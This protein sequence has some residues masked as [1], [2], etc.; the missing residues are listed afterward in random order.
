[1]KCLE[2]EEETVVL[3]EKIVLAGK[4]IKRRRECK[5]CDMQFTTIQDKGGEEE[6]GWWEVRRLKDGYTSRQTR[7]QASKIRQ[8]LCSC[9]GHR[10]ISINRNSLCDECGDRHAELMNKR[11][12]M[13]RSRK[14]RIKK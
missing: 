9:C 5:H 7:W 2:C 8:G 10:E 11:D 12:K 3:R 14:R 13:K 1:M 6:A 4:R